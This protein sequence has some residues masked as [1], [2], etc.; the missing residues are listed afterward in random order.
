MSK[1]DYYEV[2]E[3]PKTA[4]QD[5]IKKAYRKKALAHHPD[6]GGDENIFKEIAEAYEILSDDEK[7]KQYDIHGHNIPRQGPSG[8]PFDMFQDFFNRSGFNPFARNSTPRNGA[9]LNLTVKLTL[10]EIFNGVN[11]KFKYKRNTHCSNCSGKGGTGSK[12]CNT[13]NGSGI[14][15]QI[16]NTPIGQIHNSSQ[17]NVCN[18]EGFTYENICNICNGGG[19]VSIDEIVDVTIPSGVVENMTLA[20]SNKGHAVK[21]GGVGDLIMAILEVPND[22]F[23][24]SNNDLKINIKLTYPQLILGDKVEIP[25]IEGGKIR[26]QIPEYSKVGDTLKIPEKGMKQLNTNNRGDMLINLDLYIP[27][28]ITDEERHLIEELKKINKKIVS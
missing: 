21:N 18:G 19:V 28:K 24:R 25:T 15:T 20:L 27:N 26:I 17:C 23:V 9:N 8:N 1:R 7:R 4:T 2:L 16:I 14:I 5:E 11:K 13:C 12:S 3:V 6:K 10:E 22:K